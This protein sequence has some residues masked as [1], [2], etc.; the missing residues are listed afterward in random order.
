LLPIVPLQYGWDREAFLDHTCRKAGLPE[1]TWR[2]PGAE[3]L[4]FTA[5]LLEDD[6]R[7]A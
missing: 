4:A 3:L 2:K 1:D 5:E 6:G 7:D